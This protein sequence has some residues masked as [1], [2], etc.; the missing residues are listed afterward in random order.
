MELNKEGL[1]ALE[2]VAM[3][4]L[5]S[6][7]G[8]AGLE[9]FSING[10]IAHI[11]VEQVVHNTAAETLREVNLT[12]IRVEEGQKYLKEGVDTHAE[13]LEELSYHVRELH[14]EK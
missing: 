4:V 11:K 14:L 7:A 3:A 10:A 2:T 12:L 1:F 8:W 9:I 6:V 13:R 5:L